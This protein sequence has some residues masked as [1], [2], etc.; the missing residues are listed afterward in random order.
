MAFYFFNRLAEEIARTK[1]QSN[2]NAVAPYVYNWGR[3]NS[4]VA[5]HEVGEDHICTV[6][7]LS[8]VSSVCDENFVLFL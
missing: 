5:V 6:L 3:H 8:E 1:L 2:L 4:T 7:L